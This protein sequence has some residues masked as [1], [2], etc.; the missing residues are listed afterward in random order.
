ME[1]PPFH[2]GA[3]RNSATSVTKLWRVSETSLIFC[4]ARWSVSDV[5]ETV[6]PCELGSWI[7][8]TLGI[9]WQVFHGIIWHGGVPQTS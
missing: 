1:L 5:S 9:I 6:I 8:V 2:V 7:S 4:C 3:G